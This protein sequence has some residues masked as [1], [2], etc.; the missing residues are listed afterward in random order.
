MKTSTVQKF[1]IEILSEESAHFTAQEIFTQLKPKLP[2]LNPSTVYRALERLTLSGKI[3]VSDMGTGASV[4]EIVG[5]T[6]HHHLVCQG[7][8]K[9]LT[10]KNDLIQPMFDRVKEH[11]GFTLTTNHLILFGYCP[12]CQKKQGSADD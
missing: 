5:S 9:V 11:S 1:I 4:Y 6:P 7:C 3:S 10:L 12:D 8:H 2:S